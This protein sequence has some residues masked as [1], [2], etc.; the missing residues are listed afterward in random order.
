MVYCLGLEL[1]FLLK[2]KVPLLQRGG[3]TLLI[4]KFIFVKIKSADAEEID[5]I[6]LPPAKKNHTST[7]KNTNRQNITLPPAKKQKITLP[8]AKKE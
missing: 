3:F 6:T 2:S 8:P 1:A 5:A 7:C 4:N